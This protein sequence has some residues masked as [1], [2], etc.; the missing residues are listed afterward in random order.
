MGGGFLIFYWWF[1][2]KKKEKMP[3]N[4]PLHFSTILAGEQFGPI[5]PPG[6][7]FGLI[8]SSFRRHFSTREFP[9]MTP[10]SKRKNQEKGKKKNPSREETGKKN[11][12]RILHLCEFTV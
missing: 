4:L 6:K 11:P 1:Q 10:S 2:K 12:K 8:R 7:Y 3:L 9:S 5:L